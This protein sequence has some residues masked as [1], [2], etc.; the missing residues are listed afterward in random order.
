[1]SLSGISYLSEVSES[2]CLDT[3]SCQSV[4]FSVSLILSNWVYLRLTVS[5]IQMIKA[6]T[7]VVVLGVSVLFKL[8]TASAKLWGTV[9]LI[10]VGVAI[11]SYGEIQFDMLGF[12]I[13]LLA[14]RC[15]D[16]FVRF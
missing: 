1:M 7:P 13:Q 2:L 16:P 5:F 15:C 14:S 11:A 4:L 9:C 3:R 8:K 12:S 6:V 10:S